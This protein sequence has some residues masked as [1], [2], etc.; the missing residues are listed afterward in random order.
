ML[1]W[2]LVLHILDIIQIK[3][4]FNAFVMKSALHNND[5]CQQVCSLSLLFCSQSPYFH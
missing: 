4:I 1:K 5:Y 2:L 3:N